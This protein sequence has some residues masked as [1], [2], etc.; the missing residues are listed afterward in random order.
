MLLAI[1]NH[2]SI[3]GTKNTQLER[4]HECFNILN[5][6]IFTSHWFH[7]TNKTKDEEMYF[8][9]FG[10]DNKMMNLA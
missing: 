9:R 2:S 1:E 5:V 7:P 6:N 10:K 4:D 8:D 3:V